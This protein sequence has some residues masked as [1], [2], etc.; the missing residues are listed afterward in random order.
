MAAG[1]ELNATN[2]TDP[3]PDNLF[4]DVPFV[5]VNQTSPHDIFKL[6]Y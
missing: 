4:H 5:D 6:G 1:D 2:L 3:F